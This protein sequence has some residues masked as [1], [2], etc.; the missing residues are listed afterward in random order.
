[1][2]PDDLA[3]A[4]GVGRDRDYC[5]NRDDAAALA[6]LQIGGVEPQI[7]PLAGERP[8]EEGVHPL[9]DLLAE[10]GNLRLADPGEPHCL[11]Q[12]VDPSGRHAADPGLLDDCDQR[13]LR[14]L[15]GFEKRREVAAL[16]QLRD[17]QFQRAE[18]GAER[19]VAIAVAPGGALAAALVATGSDQ[20]LDI[21]FHQQLQHCLGHGSQKI[22][23][24]SLL[25]QLGQHQSLLG[26]RSSRALRVEVVANSTLADRADGHLNSTA[27]LHCGPM[28]KIPPHAWTL[29]RLLTT[30]TIIN[31]N[32]LLYHA[33]KFDCQLCELKS[34]CCPKE[35][36]RKVPRSIYKGARD[37]ARAIAQSTKVAHR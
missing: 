29:A 9:V 36:A 3:P 17:A 5:G 6:L 4:I 27:V 8:V 19:A 16:P 13:L 28:P 30:G 21:G 33:S 7:R 14:A 25:Q 26:H 24:A 1:M 31:D 34:R 2:Q 20:P 37:M 18:A 10:L 11:H 22:S 23:L 15:A 35:P 32:Q 12:I